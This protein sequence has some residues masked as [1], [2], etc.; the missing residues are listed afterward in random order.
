MT[1][2]GIRRWLRCTT[3][4]LLV[5]LALALAAIAVLSSPGFALPCSVPSCK[6]WPP[7]PPHPFLLFSWAPEAPEAGKPV[8]FQA[9]LKEVSPSTVQWDFTGS[10]SYSSQGLMPT[11]VFLN[12]GSYNVSVR[13]VTFAGHTLLTTR[14]VTVVPAIIVPAECENR[15]PFEVLFDKRDPNRLP[16]NPEWAWQCKYKGP[17]ALG[18][19][20]NPAVD[21]HEFPYGNGGLVVGPKCTNEPLSWD[22]P[23]DLRWYTVCHWQWIH[24]L[25]GIPIGFAIESDSTVHGHVNWYPVTYE[26]VLEF[27]DFSDSFGEDNDSNFIFFPGLPSAPQLYEQTTPG[28]TPAN[29]ENSVAFMTL[30]Y[31]TPEIYSAF[32]APGSNL[33]SDLA[34]ANAWQA[35][36]NRAF[37]TAIVTGLL[38]LD[39]RHSAKTELHPLYAFAVREQQNEPGADRWLIMLRNTGNEGGCSSHNPYI[40]PLNTPF[41]RL[42]LSLPSPSAGIFGEHAGRTTGVSLT[43]TSLHAY[44]AQSAVQHLSVSLTPDGTHAEVS[45]PLPPPTPNEAGV[46]VGEIT[47]KWQGVSPGAAPL[48]TNEQRG[49]ATVGI[50]H[51][52]LGSPHPDTT[53][54]SDLQ[55]IL[56]GL[57]R[58]LTPHE[59]AIYARPPGPARHPGFFHRAPTCS[60]LTPAAK[61]AHRRH[62]DRVEVEAV[63]RVFG[64]PVG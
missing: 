40:H 26:G 7:P 4:A 41:Q 20:P 55:A 33:F 27:Q 42:T 34:E 61:R 37:G 21:C 51:K 48:A 56:P 58:L 45:V 31:N 28:L 13:G 53:R 52:A 54:D 18:S 8:R 3:K 39:N 1:Q 2:G 57:E 64:C 63:R 15:N 50:P 62:Q 44:R 22:A 30:E 16:L 47:L 12:P 5:C 36:L 17:N 43:G 23:H 32:F 9:G 25:F 19:Y 29:E 14:T 60:V 46:I 35:K 59:R 38:G 49:I 11:H 24:G 6:I 10:G